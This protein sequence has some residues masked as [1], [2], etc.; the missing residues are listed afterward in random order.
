MSLDLLRVGP[1]ND[2]VNAIQEPRLNQLLTEYNDR[3]QGLGKL[4]DVAL[5]IHVN[6]NVTPFAQKARRLPILMQKQVDTELERLLELGVI[7]PVS[8]PPTWVNPIV[9]VPKDGNNIRM[10][11]DMRAPNSAII[12]EPYQIPTL[13]ELLHE[14]NGCTVFSKL[15]LNKGYH[16]IELAEESRDLTAFAT[17]KGIFRYT[18]LLFGMVISTGD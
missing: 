10:C 3:F 12:R 4:K 2:R 1:P 11:V 9:V 6:E 16:Q 7:E 8:K 17:H 15:D 18:R 14:F 13:E 5:K